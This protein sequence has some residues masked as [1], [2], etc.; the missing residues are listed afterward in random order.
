MHSVTRSE[1]NEPAPAGLIPQEVIDVNR[2]VPTSSPGTAFPGAHGFVDLGEGT[3]PATRHGRQDL[4]M[5]PPMAIPEPPK[6]RRTNVSAIFLP[7]TGL[8][9]I[10]VLWSGS[11]K[12]FDIQSLL[13][14]KPSE[15]LA[16]FKEFPDL[17]I[18]GTG[19]TTFE[20]VA[21]FLIA[22]VAGILLAMA[23][24]AIKPIRQAIFPLLVVANSVPKLAFAPLLVVWLGFGTMPK[25]MMV[26]SICFFPI[27]VSALAG[28][29]STPAELREL[30]ESMSASGWDTFVK[31]RMPWALPQIFTGLKVAISLSVIGSTVAEISGATNG[32]GYVIQSSGGNSRTDLAFASIVLLAAISLVLYYIVV[33]VERLSVRWHHETSR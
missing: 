1:A 25:V 32:L 24:A 6:R 30:S 17:L 13:L 14:P 26:I 22:T 29:T 10:L 7:I 18:T 12:L 23:L 11:I 33:G 2:P 20:S 3:D 9:A 21:G 28:L 16:A 15:V 8:A 4:R 27:V 5:E 19:V 31:I